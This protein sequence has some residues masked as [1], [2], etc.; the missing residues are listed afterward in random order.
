MSGLFEESVKR[1]RVETTDRSSALHFVAPGDVI[2]TDTGY[3][4]YASIG[5]VPTILN[6]YHISLHRG[7]GTYTLGNQ[8][9]ASVAGV[10]E[11]VNKLIYVKPLK[12]RYGMSI[13]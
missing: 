4:R 10:V 13:Y 11:R 7:H 2:T 8:L 3:M 12:S 1:P 5:D 6:N 9:C